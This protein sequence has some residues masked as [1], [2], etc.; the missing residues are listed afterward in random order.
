MGVNVFIPWWVGGTLFL[1]PVDQHECDWRLKAHRLKKKGSCML[2]LGV[3]HQNWKVF[4][5]F[6]INT[7]WLILLPLLRK[8]FL[9]PSSRARLVS[10]IDC[11][12]EVGE[13]LLN[14]FKL[15]SEGRL[16]NEPKRKPFHFVVELDH[17]AFGA[18]YRSSSAVHAKSLQ[19]WLLIHPSGF[20]VPRWHVYKSLLRNQS[21]LSGL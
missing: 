7:V 19:Q 9:F 6:H 13:N 15:N 10:L 16:W 2:L 1:L 17:L 20:P 21:L 4:P 8:L 5:P 11:N 3:S 12:R 18:C 14:A